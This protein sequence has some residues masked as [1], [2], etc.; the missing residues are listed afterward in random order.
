MTDRIVPGGQQSGEAPAG[1]QLAGG[2][3]YGKTAAI[4]SLFVTGAGQLYHK[5]Y[6]KGLLFLLTYIAGLYFSFTSLFANIAGL[7]TLGDTPSGFAKNK[8]GLTVMVQGDHSIFMMIYGIASL[9]VF[10]IFVFIHVMNIRDA[11]VTGVKRERGVPAPSFRE[12]VRRLQDK[13]FPYML[14][15]IPGLG[16]LF[17]TIMPIIFMIL[18]AFTNYNKDHLP[19]KNLVDWVGF[20]TFSNLLVYSQWAYTFWNVL[21][22]TVIWAVVATVTC[23]FGG[24]L[25]AML[26][27]QKGVRF[28]GMWRTIFIL[29]YAIP[30]FISLLIMKNM[31]NSQLGPIN[32]YFRMLGLQG[33]PWL[34]DPFWAK[35]TIVFVNMWLGIPVSMV[36]VLGILTAIPKDLYEAAEVDGASSFQKFRNITLPY[37]LFATAPLLI[38]QFAGNINNFNV[39]YLLTKGDPKTGEFAF[40]GTTDLLVTWL[41]KLTLDNQMYNIASAV[42]IL[43]FLFIASFSIW[44]FRRTRSFKEEEMLQ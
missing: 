25:V 7:I 10:L 17:F 36:L 18:L 20:K 44:N 13:S 34:N 2:K 40:A 21:L 43:I 31:F 12:T 9:L 38:M 42:G 8:Q 41:Y 33:L 3:P 22:W 39:I 4:L 35:V 15:T 6:G 14:L 16:V 26:I 24:I 37:V 5:Q 30:Q 23:Y 28:K 29:P 11:Y 19:P 27:Q 32:T 1:P